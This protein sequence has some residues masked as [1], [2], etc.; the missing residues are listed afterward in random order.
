MEG[1]RTA[2]GLGEQGRGP[3]PP[4]GPPASRTGRRSCWIRVV[5]LHHTGSVPRPREGATAA[6]PRAPSSE[7]LTLV[8]HEVK[9]AGHRL[10][11]EE[12]LGMV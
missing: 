6:T 11:G 9:G 5:C 1:H 4:W 2:H 10:E 7:P 12:A 3:A 8:P